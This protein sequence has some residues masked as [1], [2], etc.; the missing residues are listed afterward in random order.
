MKTTA[1][2]PGFWAIWHM[3]RL[4]R[5][6]GVTGIATCLLLT[7]C[8]LA[9]FVGLWPLRD[10]LA[11]VQAR[12]AEAA[13]TPRKP[14]LQAVPNG[15]DALREFQ[16]KLPLLTTAPDTLADVQRVAK[17]SGLAIDQ[18]EFRLVRQPGQSIARYEM[19]FQVNEA[20]P[21]VKGFVARLLATVP[22]VAVEHLAFRRQKVNDAKAETQVRLVAFFRG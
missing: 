22:H 16:A 15:N 18:A 1:A 11:L 17:E 21:K 2:S 12:L 13:R 7:G 8:A 10:D 5:L 3:R 19:A 9:V 6:L 14:V 4:G 20:Y